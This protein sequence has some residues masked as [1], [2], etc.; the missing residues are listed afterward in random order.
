MNSVRFLELLTKLKATGASFARIKVLSEMWRFVSGLSAEER[1]QLIRELGLEGQERV[2]ER[3]LSSP[4]TR[5]AEIIQL[6][7]DVLQRVDIEKLESSAPQILMEDSSDQ[8]SDQSVHEIGNLTATTPPAPPDALPSARSSLENSSHSSDTDNS[9][10]GAAEEEEIL[11]APFATQ[12]IEPDE[13]MDKEV[14]Q[15]AVA[16]AADSPRSQPDES[17]ATPPPMEPKELESASAGSGPSDEPKTETLGEIKEKTVAFVAPPERGST[18]EEL[19]HQLLEFDSTSARFRFMMKHGS[20][21]DAITCQKAAKL[22]E[23]FPPGWMQRRV[24]MMFLKNGISSEFDELLKLIEQ[25]VTRPSDYL[26]YAGQLVQTH[27][28]SESEAPLLVEKAPTQSIRRKISNWYQQVAI[29][30]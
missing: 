22:L 19:I 18:I 8:T 15:P 24:L 13:A 29:R 11:V 25:S 9:D 2:F 30:E 20:R 4:G 1:A 14:P 7:D 12:G 28:I 21:L 16:P 23:L 6:A 26:W 27:R 3:F 5:S 10:H 17:A